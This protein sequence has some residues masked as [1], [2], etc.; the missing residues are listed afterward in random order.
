M[1]SGA[2]RHEYGRYSNPSEQVVEQKLAELEGGESAVL[3]ASGMGRPEHA[4][5]FETPLG[6]RDRFL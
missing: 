1:T 4:F 5:A 3:F 2:L 6:G